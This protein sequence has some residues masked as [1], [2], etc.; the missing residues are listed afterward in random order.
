MKHATAHSTSVLFGHMQHCGFTEWI[1]RCCGSHH[2]ARAN[3][4]TKYGVYWTAR[5]IPWLYP[6]GRRHQLCCSL[7]ARMR[8]KST[9]AAEPGRLQ[10]RITHTSRVYGRTVI[11]S[12]GARCSILIPRCAAYANDPSSTVTFNSVTTHMHILLWATMNQ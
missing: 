4:W 8:S 1:V 3:V 6:S 5:S 11:S 2:N 10:D 7:L 12:I 9:C